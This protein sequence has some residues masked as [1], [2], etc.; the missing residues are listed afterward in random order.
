VGETSGLPATRVGRFDLAVLLSGLLVMAWSVF[1]VVRGGM[2]LSHGFLLLGTVPLIMVV[3]KFPVILEGR[4]SSSGIEIGFDSSILMFL[5]STVDAPEAVLAWSLGILG[6]QLTSGKRPG[7]MVFNTGIG[8]LSGG[9]AAAVFWTLRGPEPLTPRELAAVALAAAAYFVMD[10]V[11]SALSVAIDEG[12]SVRRSLQQRGAL[13]AIGCFVAFDLLGYLAAVMLDVA[14]WWLVPLLAVPLGT[15]LVAT[16]AVTSA[17]ENARRLKVLLNAAVRAQ[18]VY[19]P[20]QVN[21]ALAEDAAAL[22]RLGDVEV[23]NLPPR[24]DQIGAQVLRGKDATWVVAPHRDRVRS[25][26]EADKEG[27]AALAAIASDA[28]ARLQLTDDMVHFARH[29]PLTDLPNRGILQDRVAHAIQF[30]RRHHGGLALLL[31]D[32]DGFKPVNDR[33]GHAAGDRVLVHIATTL[34][35]SV[36]ASDTVARLG[37]DEFAVLLE[38]IDP[39]ETMTLCRRIL[40]GLGQGVQVAERVVPLSASIGVTYADADSTTEALLRQADLAMYEA[41]ARGKN[42]AVE[43]DA[44][45]GESRLRKLELVERLRKAVAFDELEIFYQPVIDTNSGLITGVEGL[46]RWSLDGELVSP[47]V[48]IPLA[49]EIGLVVSLGERI[50]MQA[51]A[52]AAS[53]RKVG[54]PDLKIGVN[55]SAQQL[56]DPDFVAVVRRALTVMRGGLILE[57]TE[58]EGIGDD[59]VIRAAMHQMSTFGVTFAIDDFGVGFSSIGYLQDVPARILKVDRALSRDI[60]HDERA[61][62]LLR[63]ISSMGHDLGMDVVVEGVERESQLDLVR[64]DVNATFAQGYFMHRPMPLR[65][66]LEVMAGNAAPAIATEAS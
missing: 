36:R 32:L 42:A 44:S 4:G 59:P 30:N 11:V 2:E 26:A 29:D 63:S 12:T 54:G 8:M 50:L 49:E 37:G 41:K 48:F 45:M 53:L 6:T 10:Y 43:Y 28:F 18:S 66:L 15:L 61:R 57:I 56:R 20:E 40:A 17:R 39:D 16:R 46:A 33:Y 55:V 24:E 22:L 7:A 64:D 25:T 3:A 65:A 27:L 60:D 5:L 47:D 38:D 19:E 21:Q 1:E 52:D 35:A 58:R 51:A 23:Q 31:I 9:V 14:P 13:P 62:R 34:R